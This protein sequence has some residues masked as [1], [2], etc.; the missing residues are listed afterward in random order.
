[1]S[2]FLTQSRAPSIEEPLNK[3][4]MYRLCFVLGERK[5][6]FLAM[7]TSGTRAAFFVRARISRKRIKEEKEEEKSGRNVP[8]VRASAFPR[9]KTCVLDTAREHTF[10]LIAESFPPLSFLSMPD[11]AGFA[12]SLTEFADGRGIARAGY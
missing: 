6:R 11:V 7:A 1:M 9:A 3:I 8:S 12:N 5:P 10:S 4:L 2:E